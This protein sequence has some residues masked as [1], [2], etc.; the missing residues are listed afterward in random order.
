VIALA[1]EPWAVVQQEIEP[2]WRMHYDEIA[3]DHERVPLDPDWDKYRSLAQSGTLHIVTARR[4]GEL[5]GYAFTIVSTHLHYRTTLFSFSDLYYLRPD[6]RGGRTAVRLFR[7]VEAEM[8]RLGVVKMVTN[9][10]LGHDH[11]RLFAWLGWREA[12]RLFVKAPG[13]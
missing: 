13:V 4:A 5:V 7:F 3:E 6:C 1:V 9:T 2:L 8:Q 12:E 11:R 10:K